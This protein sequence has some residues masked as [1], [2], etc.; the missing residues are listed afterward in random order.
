MHPD[1]KTS[2]ECGSCSRILAGESFCKSN[3]KNLGN[4]D[5]Y[6]GLSPNFPAKIIPIKLNGSNKFIGKSGA[7]MSAI[8]QVSVEADYDCCSLGGCCGGIGTI[9]QSLAGNGTIFLAAGGTVI[10][11]TLAANET[12]VVD[13]DSVVGFD[14]T[15]HFS[16]RMAGGPLFCCFGGEGYLNNTVTGPGQVILQSMSFSKYVAAVRPVD[17]GGDDGVEGVA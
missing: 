12:I 4:K 16:V 15:V 10:T 2:T 6:I 5:A 7:Y 3:F 14:D 8:G 1:V 11:K 9:R 13:S 17:Q